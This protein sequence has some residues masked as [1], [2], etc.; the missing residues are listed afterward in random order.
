MDLSMM[1]STQAGDVLD[2][3]LAP[4]RKRRDMVDLGVRNAFRR[5]EH[6]MPAI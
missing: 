2:C 6:G 5:L 3:V 1:C 4:V